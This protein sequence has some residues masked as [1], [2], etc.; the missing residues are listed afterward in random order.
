MAA[1]PT[2]WLWLDK[3]HPQNLKMLGL[4]LPS[5]QDMWFFGMLTA[6]IMKVVKTVI[7]GR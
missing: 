1:D 4:P 3:E 2:N 7:K 5:R 6:F